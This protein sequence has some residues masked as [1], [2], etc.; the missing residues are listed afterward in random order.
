MKGWIDCETLLPEQKTQGNGKC[1]EMVIVELSDGTI[2]KD[3]L[4]NDKWTIYCKKNGGAYPV[5]WKNGN[6]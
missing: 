4:I 1:S 2:S 3:W 5:R 6:I